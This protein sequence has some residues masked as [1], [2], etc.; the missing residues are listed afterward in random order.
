MTINAGRWKARVGLV[1]I[2]FVASEAV[3][4]PGRVPDQL[5]ARQNV[6]GRTI[7]RQ[8]DSHEWK[9]RRFVIELSILPR[10]HRVAVEAVSGKLRVFILMIVFVACKTIV[11]VFWNPD[12]RI[13]RPCVAGRAI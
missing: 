2:V 9:S 8:V 1:C 6:A 5:K 7:K 13:V 3:V 4:R 10:I 12:R 11:L